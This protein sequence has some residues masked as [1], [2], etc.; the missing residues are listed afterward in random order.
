MG[1]FDFLKK[2]K[3]VFLINDNETKQEEKSFIEKKPKGDIFLKTEYITLENIDDYSMNFI[4]IDTETTG[5]EPS[6][7]KIIEI[8]ASIFKEGILVSSFGSLIKSV[9]RV[10]EAATRVN[11][12]TSEMLIDA[13]SE[14]HVYS[15]FI[16]FIRPALN[17]EVIL[18]AH[19]A[20]FDF[21]FLSK[22]LENNGYSGTLK[23]VDTLTLA[24]RTLRS[25]PNHKQETVLTHY[26]ILNQKSHRAKEDAIA[27]GRMFIELC[28]DRKEQLI[29]E[30][31]K[32]NSY[33]YGKYNTYTVNTESITPNE[34]E[35]EICSII[36]RVLLENERDTKNVYFYKNSL[37]IVDS[38]NGWV[39]FFQFKIAKKSKYVILE[40]HSTLN[41]YQVANV[42]KNEGA[43]NDVRMFFESPVVIREL[44]SYIL[45]QFD[46][47]QKD[48]KYYPPY[49]MSSGFA[50]NTLND[51]NLEELENNAFQRYEKYCEDKEEQERIRKEKETEEIKKAE[52]KERRR[53]E[54]EQRLLEKEE[55][56]NNG[57]YNPHGKRAIYQMDD[58][59]NILKE[60]ESLSE[61]VKE[62]G[63]NS[64]SIRD[65]TNGK[66][67]RAGGYVWKYKDQM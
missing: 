40:K 12:I 35:K 63:I 44:Q 30:P 6:I 48:L 52:E 36:K 57:T 7:D 24:R 3:Q 16:D 54:R 29:N 49:N 51:C 14:E 65:T 34:E 1:L 2:E 66:Q 59:G 31:P 15:K 39:D 13:P 32:S 27:C 23:Y 47:S 20:S 10:P 43:I 61:A 55:A 19:N 22:A 53:A 62:T 60:Y 9:N 17:D 50:I 58:N 67:K 42:S 8:G 38:R 41:G 37:G 26:S 28:R 45:S 18:V 25:L 33:E 46:K 11:H 5:L 21:G 4:A 56:I 64:K